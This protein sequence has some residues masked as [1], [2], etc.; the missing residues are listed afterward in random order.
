MSEARCKEEAEVITESVRHTE[1]LIQS[2]TYS[3]QLIIV[4]KSAKNP[5]EF[6][7]NLF[8]LLFFLSFLLYLFHN[9]GLNYIITCRSDYRSGFGLPNRFIGYSYVITTIN[10]NTLR[11]PVIIPHK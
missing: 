11:I 8:V 3:T 4:A 9:L 7:V 6:V 1:M 10:Y 2:V 5:T